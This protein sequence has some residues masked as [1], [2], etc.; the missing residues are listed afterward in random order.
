MNEVFAPTLYLLS[1]N[2]SLFFDQIFVPNQQFILNVITIFVI[3]NATFTIPN[4]TFTIELDFLNFRIRSKMIIKI[5][6]GSNMLNIPPRSTKAK[7]YTIIYRDLQVNVPYLVKDIIH[8]KNTLITSKCSFSR[9]RHNTSD[10]Y[11]H[12]DITRGIY[13]DP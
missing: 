6:R 5:E 7:K 10:E 2:S 4:T 13:H 8:R 12:K 1:R 3:L 9:K 11:S